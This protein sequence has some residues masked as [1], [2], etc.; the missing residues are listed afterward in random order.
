MTSKKT[1]ASLLQRIGALQLAISPMARILSFKRQWCVPHANE[2]YLEKLYSGKWDSWSSFVMSR[3]FVQSWS[4]LCHSIV[5]ISIGKGFACSS[6]NSIF[7]ASN[8]GWARKH[9]GCQ[10]YVS[11]FALHT[12]APG[13]LISSTE[14]RSRRNPSALL[15]A[16]RPSLRI[17]LLLRVDQNNPPE[18]YEKGKI[19]TAN[20]RSLSY[21]CSNE[22]GELMQTLARQMRLW[23]FI[24]NFHFNSSQA[25][26]VDELYYF[27]MQ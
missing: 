7:R 4:R 26:F 21:E 15:V 12:A 8:F 27:L 11:Q 17:D 10:C 23:P 1:Y 6:H 3:T 18:S 2:T 22:N 5:D 20:Y 9:G 13:A 16:M 14:K 24:Q 25:L 19:S